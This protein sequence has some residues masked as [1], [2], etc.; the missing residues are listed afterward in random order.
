MPFTDELLKYVDKI[1][2]ETGTYQG[3]TIDIVNKHKNYQTTI[4]SIE[5]SEIFHK[6]CK[7]K[8]KNTKNVEIIFGNSKYHL[9]NIIN[10][11][12]NK[13][14]F[15]LDSHW[16]GVP[17]IGCDNV[18]ICPILF[19]L[20]QIKLHHIKNHTI[21]VDDI[22]LMDNIHFPVT[23][24][25]IIEKIYEINKDYTIVYYDDY[26]AKNDILV[27]YI[28]PK[29]IHKYLYK[30]KT[31]RQSPGFA[32]FLRGT[33]A[34]YEYSKKYDYNFYI[35]RNVHPI[36]D[37]FENS[38]YF[39]ND[40][41]N[42]NIIELLPPLLYNEIDNRLK[43][44]FETKQDFNILTNSFI[45]N[46]NN[47][48]A[49][50]SSLKFETKTFLKEILRPNCNIQNKINDIFNYNYN[51][52]LDDMFNVIHIRLGDD[53]LYNEE[54]K[55]IELFSEL[56]NKINSLLSKNDE[57]YILITDSNTFGKYIQE[58][59]LNIYYWDNNKTH[60]GDKIDNKEGLRDSIIDFFI[61]CKANKIYALN[62]SGFS[63]CISNIFDKDYILI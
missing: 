34:L 50:F 49:N 15:W 53:Y 55:N 38:N 27:A 2:I 22:R 61:M 13:I 11:I 43:N 30:C 59:K 21:I 23:K 1:F 14:T 46:E 48:L 4:F 3:E 12:N 26:T 20:E 17:N 42:T 31:N 29:C 35:D 5:L 28:K 18:S 19:E 52:K 8:F 6:N 58:N 9:I 44:L 51:I 7:E 63:K 40:N 39:I 16:S 54:N 47:V 32:D 57:R 10:D 33:I 45:Y 24:E 62:E 60:I 41:N 36:F 25:Q 56:L 37:Y